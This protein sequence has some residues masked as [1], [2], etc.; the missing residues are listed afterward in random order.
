MTDCQ[1]AVG[2]EDKGKQGCLEPRSEE[3]SLKG[4]ADDCAGAGDAR[5][6]NEL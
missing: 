3:L 4:G 1:D 6:A 2:G 5:A